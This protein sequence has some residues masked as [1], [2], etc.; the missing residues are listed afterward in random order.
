MNYSYNNQIYN[1]NI[2]FIPRELYYNQQ[3]QNQN[4][5][6]KEMSDTSSIYSNYSSFSNNSIN[7]KKFNNNNINYNNNSLSYRGPDLHK[8]NKNKII[9]KVKFNED[10]NVIKVQSY[11]IYNKEDEN[12][13]FG[14]NCNKR[15]YGPN[16]I[17]KKDGGKCDCIII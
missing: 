2:K 11:K 17:S 15:Y 14:P 12:L 7:N 16:R 5:L 13:S 1:N 6:T 9:K 4:Q 10:V 3:Y 8:K